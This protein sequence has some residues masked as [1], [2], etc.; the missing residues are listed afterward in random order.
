MFKECRHIKPNGCK[1]KSPALKDKP[2][3]YYHIRVHRIARYTGPL[4]P[5][6]HKD[7]Q[8]PFLEDRGAVQIAL[9]E[10][11]SALA[12]HRIEFKRA[13]LLIYALQVASSNARIPADLV[14]L[15]QVRDA[16][17]D[18]SGEELAPEIT[19]F[20]P[21]DEEYQEA[22]HE[23]TLAE[24]LMAEVHRHRDEHEA[25]QAAEA[26]PAE[27]RVTQA[28]ATQTWSG[29]PRKYREYLPPST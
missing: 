28:P 18:E 11:V 22:N 6:E 3:C 7:L 1:C 8:I 2:Y 5:H 16:S 4:A 13:G 26:Q 24:I 23:P 29:D 20:E 9:S 21:D 12:N 27:A 10:V 17:E 14:A 19:T 15:E 25:K